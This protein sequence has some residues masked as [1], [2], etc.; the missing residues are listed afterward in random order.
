LTP[1]PTLGLILLQI[2]TKTGKNEPTTVEHRLHLV[3]EDT[4]EM[5]INISELMYIEAPLDVV[6]KGKSNDSEDGDL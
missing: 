6:R 3:D 1:K 2:L 5:Y 4:E